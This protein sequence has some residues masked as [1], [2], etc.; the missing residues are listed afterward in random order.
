MTLVVA[1]VLA[2]FIGAALGALGAGGS[3]L[4]LPVLV[5]VAGVPTTAAVP[6]SLLVVGCSAVIAAI[7]RARA[8][9]V[10]WR[11]AGL[12]AVSGAAAAYAGGAVNRLLDPRLVLAGFGLLLAAAGVRML[13]VREESRRTGC[14]TPGGEIDWHRCLPRATGVGLLVGFLTGLFGVEGGFLHRPRA[15]GGT[16]A[17]HRGGGGHVAGDHR[18]ELVQRSGVLGR[19]R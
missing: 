6:M 11:I 12:F 17:A 2:L 14:A 8:G 4:A 7:N 18:S 19:A 3:I 9:H 15:R 5:F 13:L 1:F 16:G 10:R